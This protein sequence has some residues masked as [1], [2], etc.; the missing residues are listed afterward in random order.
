MSKRVLAL[1]AALLM[2]S[3]LFAGCSKAPGG[4]SSGSAGSTGSAGDT[5]SPSNTA[6]IELPKFDIQG[7]KV[8]YLGW[9]SGKE[10]TT[11]GTDLYRL[12]Q[13]LKEHYGAEIQFVRTT[14]DELPTKLAQLVLSS[15]SPDLVHY[16]YQD[17]PG[18]ILNELVT[19]ITPDLIDFD[20]ALWS[21][22]KEV[23][24]EYAFNGKIFTPI[25]NLINN[26]YIYY[27]VQMFEEAGL[28]T[29][30]ELYRKGEWTWDTM[31]DLAE[32]LTV[33]G[34]D[35]SVKVY[36]M[37]TGSDF[38]MTCGSDF[39]K[40]NEDGT[41]TNN[42]SDPNLA[43]V[44]NYIF[45][46][47]TAGSNCRMMIGQFTEEFLAGNIAMICDEAWVRSMLYDKMK[48]GEVRFAPSP[49]MPDADEYYVNSL[50][51]TLW[52]AKNAPNPQGAAAYLSIM[53]YV[54][55]EPTAKAD[56]RAWE[57]EKMGYTAEEYALIDEMND[58]S[59]FTFTRRIG[60]GVGNFGNKEMFDMFNAVSSWDIPWS[61]CVEQ[62]K[63]LLQAE[64]D[65]HNSKVTAYKNK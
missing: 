60:P 41:V 2:F 17:N 62:Y 16:K 53:R 14:Y 47:G 24:Q 56:F 30:L 59:K 39:A 33:K 58:R 22:I 18:F 1:S 54:E 45:R 21:G 12:N 23:N 4:E 50:I 46:T 57:M 51:S 36:G 65:A 37:T 13:M 52:I 29:P 32:Q 19:E 55:T 40:A 7:T 42:L 44:F 9:A 6:T 3:M 10:F 43:K 15:N 11:E 26:G 20:S 49:K 8:Q 31:R 34:S 61:T 35:G 63:P 28:E 5:S 64:I 48:S 38:Y 27:N 25:V